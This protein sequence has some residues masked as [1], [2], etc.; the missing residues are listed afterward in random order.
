MKPE[1]AYKFIKRFTLTNTTIMTILF[2]IQ[3]NS[4]WHAFCLIATLPVIGIGMIAMY[5]Y[6]AYDY[7]NLLNNLT[8]KKKKET[9]YIRWDEA[10]KDAR[11]DYLRGLIGITFCNILFSGLIIFMLWQILYEGRLLRIS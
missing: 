1:T 7:T 11:K 3:C 8:E 10:I 4:L 5:E 2:V 9:P 6:Y